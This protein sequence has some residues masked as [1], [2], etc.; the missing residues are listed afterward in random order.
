MHSW[1]VQDQQHNT[2]PI[3]LTERET[4]ILLHVI[5]GKQSKEVADEL[6]ISKRTVEY[7]LASIYDKLDVSNRMQ[8]YHRAVRL[9]LLPTA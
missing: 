1:N 8:A 7:H 3:R 6:F 5:Q 2:A 4:E 9:G